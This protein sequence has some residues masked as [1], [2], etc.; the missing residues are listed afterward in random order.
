M[1]A[2]ATRTA[3]T[4]LARRLARAAG[5]ALAGLRGSGP[6]GR[7]VAADIAD[8]RSTAMPP[9]A[10]PAARGR[11]SST[12][13]ARRQ[14]RG[15]GIELAAIT[16][17]GPGGR[18]VGSDIARARDVEIVVECRTAA[19][20]SLRDR[21]NLALPKGAVP[22]AATDL[23]VKAIAWALARDAAGP[24]D[25]A[26][27]DTGGA[28]RQL[29]RGADRSGAAAIA[30][31]RAESP[32]AHAGAATVAARVGPSGGLRLTIRPGAAAQ[33]FASKAALARRIRD[34]IEW[35]TALLL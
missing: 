14:A 8:T 27:V 11:R 17:S 30:A 4:P 12:P 5:I 29:V 10:A 6:G 32:S 7:I 2:T 24:V 26:L 15:A 31:M 23:L 9:A 25:I 19:L 1:N 18:I 28:V 13:Y 20:E 22:I 21:L 16:G 33:G 35:P 3:S 34:A